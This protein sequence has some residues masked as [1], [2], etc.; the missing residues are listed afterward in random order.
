M[1]RIW[2]A[3][4]RTFSSEVGDLDAAA[5]AAATGVNLGLDHPDLAAQGFGCL[6]RVIHGGAVNPARNRHAEFLQE[7]FALIFVNLHALSLR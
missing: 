5:L 7:L 6:D 2:P 1:P 3:Y 4:S